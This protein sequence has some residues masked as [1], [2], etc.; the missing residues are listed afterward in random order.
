MAGTSNSR[1]EAHH[2]GVDDVAVGAD[3]ELD[4][5]VDVE[6]ILDALAEV[7][8]GLGDRNGEGIP[9]EVEMRRRAGQVG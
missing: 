2:A 5:I 3:D 6:Q 1:C 7:G 9:V 4:E 8:A